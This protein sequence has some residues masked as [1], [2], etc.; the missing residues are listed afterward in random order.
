MEY[1]MRK[2]GSKKHHEK[3]L[4]KSPKECQNLLNYKIK[5]QK[6]KKKIKRINKNIKFALFNLLGSLEAAA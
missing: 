2:I 5:Q 6:T 4:F 1:K 3:S